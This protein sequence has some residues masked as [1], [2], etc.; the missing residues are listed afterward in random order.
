MAPPVTVKVFCRTTV[1]LAKTSKGYVY[2]NA[3]GADVTVIPLAA[4]VPSP[5]GNMIVPATVPP[6]GPLTLEK[7]KL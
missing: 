1:R 4:K 7:L 6:T 2:P 5:S 3:A